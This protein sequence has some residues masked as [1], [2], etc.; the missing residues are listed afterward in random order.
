M[1]EKALQNE[2][3]SA[4]INLAVDKDL[5]ELDDFELRNFGTIFG[6]IQEIQ[7]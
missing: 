1:N 6:S 3:K 5:L 7:E 2:P 4:L